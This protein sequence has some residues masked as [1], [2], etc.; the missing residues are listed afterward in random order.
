MGFRV[1]Y[2]ACLTILL[3][4]GCTFQKDDEL[5]VQDV[6]NVIQT[7][8]TSTPKVILLVIDSLMDES[9]K[10]AIEENKAPALAFFMNNGRYSNQLVS[11]YPT[12]SVTIDSSLITGTYPNEHKIP[13]LVWY[14]KD[15]E[16]MINYGNGFFEMMKIGATQFAEDAIYQ[17]NNV[18]LSPHV[19]TIHEAL[20]KRGRSSASINTIIYRG[21]YKHELKIPEIIEKTTGLP[22][23]YNTLGPKILSLG[24]LIHQ[25]EKNNHLVHRLGFN[26]S[27]GAE[28]LIYLLEKNNLPDFTIIYFPINDHTVHKNGPKT[29]KGIEKLDKQLQNILNAFPNW[30]EALNGITWMIIGDSKQ[31]SV[32]DDKEEALINLSSALSNYSILKLGEKVNKSD[33]LAIT[34]NERMAYV[35]KIKQSISLQDILSKLK[36]DERIAWIAWKENGKVQVVSGKADANT[37]QFKPGGKF[38]DIYNQTWSVDGDSSILDLTIDNNNGIQYGNYPDAL[39]RLYGAM[40][41]QKGDFIILDAKPGYEF[42]GESSP[43]HTGGGAHGSMHKDDS[44]API[45]V[46]EMNQRIDHLRMVDLKQWT[47][48]LFDNAKNE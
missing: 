26:D 5:K 6:P 13:G 37:L 44:L 34:A 16:R 3:M 38:N 46:T 40:Y 47:L 39:A 45:I 1:I 33:E 10:K 23:H 7:K 14:N 41:S 36:A 17:F 42:I 9:L 21:N 15:Q 11:A 43:Q 18:D 28:E 31:S 4:I 35:Y 25:D 8:T 20:E 48:N 22:D 27:F 2:I 29:I 19:E 12:M 32:N 24:A 30:D